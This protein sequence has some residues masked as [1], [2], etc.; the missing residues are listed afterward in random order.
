MA[1]LLS[2][3]AAAA[4]LLAAGAAN[5]PYAGPLRWHTVSPAGWASLPAAPGLTRLEAPRAPARLPV[6]FEISVGAAAPGAVWGLWLGAADSVWQALVSADGYLSLA[7]DGQQHW[8][9]FM[10]IRPAAPNRLYLHLDRAGSAVLRVND[11]IAWAGT[12]P[13]PQR[14]GVIFNDTAAAAWES[15]R[16]YHE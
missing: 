15:I 4:L 8:F 1:V 14:W 2:I 7:A 3:G 11:E 5:P 10:H 6:T 9:E 12:L 16:L 13:A